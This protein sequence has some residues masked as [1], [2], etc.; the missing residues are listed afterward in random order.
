MAKKRTKELVEDTGK[1]F[2]ELQKQLE[3]AIQTRDEYNRLLKNARER[4]ARRKKSDQPNKLALSFIESLKKGN[5]LSATLIAAIDI[6]ADVNR[7][8]NDRTYKIYLY[9]VANDPSIYKLITNGAGWATR[10]DLQILYESVAG[11]LNDWAEGIENYREV[12]LKTKGLDNED[13]GERAT[14]F[15][16]DEVY[17]T[18]LEGKT[19]SGRLAVTPHGKAPFWRILNS[20]ST[21][22]ASDRPGGYNPVHATPTDFIGVAE[23]AI[24]EQ[25]RVFMVKESDK[26]FEEEKKIEEIIEDHQERRDEFSVEVTRLRTDVRLNEK[27]YKGFA[28][29]KQ[30]IDRNLLARA[31]ASMDNEEKFKKRTINIAKKGSGLE[32]LVTVK[33]LEGTIEY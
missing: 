12:V 21:S 16:Y 26:W 7:E 3:F 31:I 14:E 27:I 32:L 29:K 19:I 15:W 5:L 23:R 24:E 25:F 6:A 11:D 20:G 28:D 1:D 9:A 8:F 22:L 30:Y 18:S 2:E 4:L 13:R 10:L 17:G 33:K